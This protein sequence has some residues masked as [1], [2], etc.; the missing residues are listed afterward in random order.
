LSERK[1]KYQRKNQNN[2]ENEYDKRPLYG[3]H[4]PPASALYLRLISLGFFSVIPYVFIFNV[5]KKK[6]SEGLPLPG[7]QNEI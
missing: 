2:D 6:N 1:E 5:E 4:K 3:H 7:H